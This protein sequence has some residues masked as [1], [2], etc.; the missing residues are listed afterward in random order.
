LVDRIARLDRP[1]RAM[2][3]S[4]ERALRVEPGPAPPP[5]AELVARAREGDRWARGALYR[6]YA[7]PVAGMLSRLIGQR[8]E[9]LDVLHDAYLYA[10]KNLATLRDDDRF[11][12][13]L[14]QI[15]VSMARSRLRRR[16]LLRALGFV[17]IDDSSLEALSG[18]AGP[19]ARAELA[20]IDRALRQMPIDE[21]IAWSLRH[22]EGHSMPE[23]A[24]QAGCSLSTAKRR[25]DAA[26]RRVAAFVGPKEAP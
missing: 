5:D 16:K 7:E 2:A 12:P 20:G 18:E 4:G 10:F 11:R 14:F 24:A 25:V 9:A 23:V 8:D 21:R 3:P 17:Q 26:E 15:A 19:D 13:W 1:T 6:R 22:V